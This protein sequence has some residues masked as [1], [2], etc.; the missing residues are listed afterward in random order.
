MEKNDKSEEIIKV[1]KERLKDYMLPKRLKKIY[2]E[3]KI[4]EIAM[5]AEKPSVARAIA[6]TLRNYKGKT[7]YKKDFKNKGKEKPVTL[8]PDEWNGFKAYHFK[9]TFKGFPAN[10]TMLSVFGNIYK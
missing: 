7:K 9:S 1:N 3:N 5:I 8:E 6:N 4:I 10:I 2:Q